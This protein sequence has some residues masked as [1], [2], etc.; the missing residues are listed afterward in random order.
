MSLNICSCKL[1]LFRRLWGGVGRPP[2]PD[3]PPG[4]IE[5]EVRWAPAGKKWSAQVRG[6]R[7]CISNFLPEEII[8]SLRRAWTSPGLAWSTRSDCPWGSCSCPKEEQCPFT[9]EKV[10]P[11]E[12][13][14]PPLQL[15]GEVSAKKRTLQTQLVFKCKLNRNMQFPTQYCVFSASFI[16][17]PPNI[18]IL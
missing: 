7:D 3:Q 5:S 15:A 2:R 18:I 11:A 13:G 17:I 12:K 6:G 9:W 4:K 16:L 1:E 14:R 8:V 10:G